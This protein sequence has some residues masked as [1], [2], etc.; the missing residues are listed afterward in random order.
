[1]VRKHYIQNNQKIIQKLHQSWINCELTNT[2]INGNENDDEDIE[3]ENNGN[4][5]LTTEMDHKI[6]LKKK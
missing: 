4:T 1:M 6:N 2:D 3:N 5:T